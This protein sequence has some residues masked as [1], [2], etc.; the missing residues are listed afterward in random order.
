MINTWKKIP[1]RISPHSYYT[2]PD[3]NM[4]DVISCLD[5]QPDDEFDFY[6]F[7]RYARELNELTPDLEAVLP[8]TDTRFRPD[9]RYKQNFY[10]LH[11]N[12]VS[13]SVFNFSP[14]SL[15]QAPGGG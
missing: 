1:L 12:H 2:L 11:L 14:S 4:H 6:G 5:V 7:S 8:P 15:Q 10:S 3:L 9:Q 13:Q